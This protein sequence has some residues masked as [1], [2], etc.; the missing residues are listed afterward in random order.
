MM[1]RMP[2]LFVAQHFAHRLLPELK[3][4]VWIASCQLQIQRNE[5]ITRI[6]GEQD[7]FCPVKLASRDQILAANSVPA[8]TFGAMLEQI[9]RKD[10]SAENQVVVTSVRNVNSRPKRLQK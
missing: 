10:Q 1:A 6:S 5:T 3:R 9:V 4:R 7:D 2:N 8:I